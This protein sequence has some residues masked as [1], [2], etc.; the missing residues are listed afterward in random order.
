[1]SRNPY[2]E[3]RHRCAPLPEDA[4]GYLFWVLAA[5]PLA[6]CIFTAFLL[7]L[8]FCLADVLRKHL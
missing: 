1:M 7:S 6:V 2:P 3:K 4:L 5:V 8:P